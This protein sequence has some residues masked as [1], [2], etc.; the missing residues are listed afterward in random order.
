MSQSNDADAKPPTPSGWDLRLSSELGDKLIEKREKLS[1]FMV[2]ASI[3]VIVFTFNNLNKKDSI[4]RIRAGTRVFMIWGSVAL[5][6]AALAALYS[7]YERHRQYARWL[8]VQDHGDPE[9]KI[10]RRMDRADIALSAAAIGLPT[11][12]LTGMSLLLVAYMRS[13]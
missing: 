7:I 6:L 9:G 3:G 1:Y 5:L 13:I 11:A 4:L 10:S 2:T 8:T 12:F